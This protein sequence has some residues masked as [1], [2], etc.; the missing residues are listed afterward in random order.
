M[1]ATERTR[2]SVIKVPIKM[3]A[4]S[5]GTQ[6]KHIAKIY[7]TF[8]P[9]IINIIAWRIE[10]P[11]VK[12]TYAHLKHVRFRW[13]LYFSCSFVRLFI[14]RIKLYRCMQYTFENAPKSYGKKRRRIT[15]NMLTISQFQSAPFS[16]FLL[17]FCYVVGQKF[18]NFSAA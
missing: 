11:C 13:F 14:H 4:I 15:I 5:S 18:V 16:P 3:R 17:L 1:H 9:S 7:S 12:Y 6:M 8:E 10:I 2:E